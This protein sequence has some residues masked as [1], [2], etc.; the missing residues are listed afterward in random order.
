MFINGQSTIV[1]KVIQHWG[2]VELITDKTCNVRIAQSS[3]C[4]TCAAHDLC[5]SSESQEKIIQV[6]G[7]YP[8][9]KKGQK[10]LVEGELSQGMKAVYIAYLIP[11]AIMVPALW[12]GIYYFNEEVGAAFALLTTSLYYG[13]LFCIKDKIGKQFSFRIKT[14]L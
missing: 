14:D 3:A 12:A 1:K 13:V 5:N 7:H 4:S 6:F 11:L 2:T 9:L 10:V 8:M